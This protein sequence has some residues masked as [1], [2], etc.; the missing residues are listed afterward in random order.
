MNDIA[1][2]GNDAGF[3]VFSSGTVSSDSNNGREQGE[4]AAQIQS[5]RK[6]SKRVLTLTLRDGLY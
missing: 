5:T 2:L 3:S 4:S 6:F 1:T